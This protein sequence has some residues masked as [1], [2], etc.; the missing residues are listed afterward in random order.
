MV[1]T[2]LGLLLFARMPVN[3][4]YA[5]D[6]LPGMILASLGMGAIFMPLTLVATTGLKNE[7][8]GLASG[9]FN[10]S[11]QVGGALG[12][13]VLTTIAVGHTS[14]AK[15]LASIVH[16][17]QWAFGGAAVLVTLSLVVLLA[18]LRKQ[19]VARIEEEARTDDEPVFASG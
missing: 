8:Q 3:G 9:L 17:W 15:S 2:I 10:T 1:L 19:D 4:S 6:V 13:A 14:D 11:Q 5:T 16:G 12:L 18:L 7:D